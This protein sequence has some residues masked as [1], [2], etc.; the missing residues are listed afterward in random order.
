MI[1]NWVFIEFA[2]IVLAA[3]FAWQH[4]P[5]GSEK[6]A[7]GLAFLSGWIVGIIERC[8]MKESPGVRPPQIGFHFNFTKRKLL[9]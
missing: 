6:F 4:M 9:T 8:C 5:K 2:A 1:I 7:R 3:L